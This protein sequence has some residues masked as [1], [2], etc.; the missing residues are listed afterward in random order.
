MSIITVDLRSRTPIFEQI[1]CSVEDLV[2]RGMMKPD[3]QLPSVR[4]LS[5]ELGINPNTIQKAYAE[6]ER[7]GITYSVNTRGSFVCSDLSPLKEKHKTD[8][9]SR[10]SVMLEDA[11]KKGISRKEIMSIIEKVW[12]DSND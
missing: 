1:V 7:R 12:R 4:A 11:G 8:T 6:L 5:A 3:E 2:L 10:L 9:L